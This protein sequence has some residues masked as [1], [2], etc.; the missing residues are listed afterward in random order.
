MWT[1]IKSDDTIISKPMNYRSTLLQLI[2]V[3]KL[4]YKKGGA[5]PRSSVNLVLDIVKAVCPIM[6]NLG[7]DEGT[8]PRR[9]KLVWFVLIHSEN[10]IPFLE[11][12]TSHI[13]G[14]ETTQIL[15]ADGRPDQSHLPFFL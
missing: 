10:Q 6:E 8:F 3:L 11:G 14:V 5:G 13:S 1:K 4:K 15:L 9:S 7:D 2:R 12:S